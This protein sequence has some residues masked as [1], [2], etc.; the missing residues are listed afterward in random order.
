[1]DQHDADAATRHRIAGIQFQR[2]T[3]LREAIRLHG[4]LLHHSRK[5]R[6]KSANV[7]PARVL[8][9]RQKYLGFVANAPASL[10]IQNRF[11]IKN[12]AAR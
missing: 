11:K 12:P 1:M 2:F 6:P 3:K 7:H 4:A 9:L 8:L 5:L 10:L